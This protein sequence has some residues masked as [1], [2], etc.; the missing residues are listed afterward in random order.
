MAYFPPT[1]SVVAFQSDGTKLGVSVVG[2]TP[3]SISNFPTTQNVSGSVVAFVNGIV[4]VNTAGSV[5]AF[6]G[7]SPWVSNF[8]NSSILAVP[9]GSMI[10]VAQS[11]VAVAIVSGSIAASFTPPANQSVSGTVQVDVRASVATVIIGGS[12]AASFTPPANQSVSG[13]VQT[14]VRASVAVVIIGGSVAT[15]TTNSSVMLLNGA[16]VIGSVTALQGT[17]P[18]IDTFS[19]SS[20]LAVPVGSIITL[21]QGS[22]ILSVPIGSTITT[23]QSPSIVGTYA[24]DA[25]HTSGDKGLFALAVRNDTVSSTAS[26]DLDYTVHAVDSAGRTVIK[27]FVPEDGTIISYVGSVVSASVT[28]IQASAVGKRNYITDFWA[29]N[30]GSVSALITFQGGDTSIVGYTIAPAGGGS[31]SPGIAVPLK[32]NTSQDLAFKATGTSSVLYLTVKGYQAP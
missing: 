30:T 32:S 28:L 6:Q 4:P 27:P 31:N 18:W 9:V 14:D 26:N 24:E 8:Q 16:N 20:I 1:G 25:G 11:S 22:S 2:L 5:V 13:T 7:T 17:N 21:N 29:T 19:N 23:W 3:V 12:I 15:A 10:T